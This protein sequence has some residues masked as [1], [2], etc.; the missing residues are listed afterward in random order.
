MI[1]TTTL[2]LLAMLAAGAVTS[3]ASAPPPFGTPYQAYRGLK[4]RTFVGKPSDIRPAVL[5]ALRELGFEV[6]PD[7]VERTY[8]TGNRGMGAQPAAYPSEQRT[9]MRV[10]VQIRFVDKHRR[11]PR[12]LVE[13][14]AENIQGTSEGPIEA[15]FGAV[16]SSFYD[17][18][19]SIIETKAKP[20]ATTRGLLPPA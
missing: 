15:S 14:D 8:I 17:E 13:I 3:C 2:S 18:F 9:W 20:A 6:H 4:A 12:T 11:A 19:F 5:D 7:T 16:P 10:G 1:R